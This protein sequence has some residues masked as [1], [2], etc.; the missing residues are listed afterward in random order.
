MKLNKFK[1]LLAFLLVCGLTVSAASCGGETSTSDSSTQ[2][3]E[4][5]ADSSSDSADSSA[6]QPDTTAPVITYADGK[7]DS[8]TMVSGEKVT[9]PSATAADEKDGA[10]DVDV[11]VTSKGASI[12]KTE[13]GYEFSSTTAG[14]Y[15]IWKCNILLK[16]I[17]FVLQIQ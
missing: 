5:V 15:Q 2:S 3:S 13:A 9:L 4:S 16:H 14:T 12:V 11:S 8:Y 7:K 1:S 10:V 6:E 17:I